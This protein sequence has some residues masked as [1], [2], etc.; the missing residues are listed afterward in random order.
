MGVYVFRTEVLLKLL[1]WRYPA[2]NDFGSEIIPAAVMDQN[3]QV[4]T[5]KNGTFVLSSKCTTD[6]YQSNA[7]NSDCHSYVQA[8]I[9]N[10]YWEDIGTIRSFYEANLALTE[11]VGE[12]YIL[13][14]RSVL[15]INLTSNTCLLFAVSEIRVL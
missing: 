7:L 9:F 6:P 4:R 15:E 2:S 8:Y 1:R 12:T 13:T 11:E 10:D 5:F 14:N 3:V